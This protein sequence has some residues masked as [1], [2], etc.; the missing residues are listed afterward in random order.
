MSFGS[1]PC[2]L[3]Q[4]PTWRLNVERAKKKAHAYLKVVM[5]DVR[6][7]KRHATSVRE[8]SVPAYLMMALGAS[9]PSF[10]R[11]QAMYCTFISEGEQKNPI[12]LALEKG[13][14]WKR[15]ALKNKNVN[16]SSHDPQTSACN[17]PVDSGPPSPIPK[18]L[19]AGQ[20][21]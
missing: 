10:C 16:N 7:R 13:R 20:V 4:V 19:I 17:D 11:H 1:F 14:R 6:H 12:I 2:F 3:L 5:L 15:N 8:N 18:S 21:H 9:A